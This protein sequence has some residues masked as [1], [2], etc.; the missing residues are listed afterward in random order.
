[1][2]FNSGL[3]F[4]LYIVTLQ[5]NFIYTA[6]VTSVDEERTGREERRK[7][8]RGEDTRGGEGRTD[9]GVF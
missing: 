8:R 5:Y 4:Y 6:S 9:L 2:E 1:M 3:S 7:K